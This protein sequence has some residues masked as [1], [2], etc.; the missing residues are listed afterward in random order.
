M[1]TNTQNRGGAR[2]GA[3]RKKNSG[4]F[5]EDTKVMRVPLSLWVRLHLLWRC[6]NLN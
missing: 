5:K 1:T 6:T 2:L 4:K 3:G